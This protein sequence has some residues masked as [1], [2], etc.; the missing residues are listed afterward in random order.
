MHGY[1]V[2]HPTTSSC[3]NPALLYVLS[4]QENC[5]SSDHNVFPLFNVTIV[6]HGTALS[7]PPLKPTL[8]SKYLSSQKFG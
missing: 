7:F 1:L 4:L 2:P 6:F 5:L 3:N 8:M